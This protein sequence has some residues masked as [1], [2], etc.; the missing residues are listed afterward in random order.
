MCVGA[1]PLQSLLNESENLK[2][3]PGEPAK[4]LEH[5]GDVGPSVRPSK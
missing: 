5:A 3:N 4:R 2:L 1:W